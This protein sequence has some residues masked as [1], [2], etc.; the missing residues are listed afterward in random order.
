[1]KKISIVMVIVLAG[2]LMLIPV[3]HAVPIVA[4]DWIEVNKIG[5]YGT[6]GGG[7]FNVLLSSTGNMAGPYV[8]AGFKTFCLETDE[9]LSDP[10]IVASVTKDADLGGSGGPSPDPISG[11]TAYL[12]YHYIQ[13]DLDVLSGY[14]Y[15]YNDNNSANDLQKAIWFLEQ[16]TGV[17][18]NYLVVLGQASIWGQTNFTGNVWVMNTENRWG[19]KT[20]DFLQVVPEPS[21]LLLLGAGLL[22][23]ALYRRRKA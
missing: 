6:T 16:E 11:A 21:T 23:L 20:Q 19:S 18:S 2:L 12:Y 9:Y 13:G 5:T 10:M 7:E 22:S 8:Y 4:G 1:M 15:Q 14:A 3:A 17:V